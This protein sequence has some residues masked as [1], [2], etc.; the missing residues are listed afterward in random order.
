MNFSDICSDIYSEFSIQDTTNNHHIYEKTGST[1]TNH[2]RQ[3]YDKNGCMYNGETGSRIAG[4]MPVH[5]KGLV[6]VHVLYLVPMVQEVQ[7]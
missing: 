2:I 4:Q 1:K 5:K 6:R 7:E 3:V